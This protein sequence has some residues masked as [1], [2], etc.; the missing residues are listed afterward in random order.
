MKSWSHQNHLLFWLILFALT[1]ID[2]PALADVISGT[3][4]GKGDNSA[5]LIQIVQTNDGNL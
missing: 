2:M 3:Y 5:F 4:V 1:V